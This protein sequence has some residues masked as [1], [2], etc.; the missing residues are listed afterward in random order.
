M[1][2][3]RF[4]QIEE[5][6][7]AAMA[8]EPDC[9]AAML[10]EAC[11]GDEGLRKEVEAL[12]AAEQEPASVLKH[13]LWDRRDPPVGPLAPGDRLGPYEIVSQIGAGGMGEVY[14]ARDKRLNRFVAVKVLP[15]D[16]MADTARKQRFIQEARA[17]SALNHPNI[18]TIHDIAADCDRD[19]LVMEYVAGKTLDDLIPRAGMRLGEL[20]KIA[21]QA[22]EGLGAAH[23]AGIVH[24]DLKPSNMIVS[25]NGVVK[26]LDFGLAKLREQPTLSRRPTTPFHCGRRRTK[27]QSWARRLICRRSRQKASRSM[28]AAISSVSAGCSTRWPPAAAHLRAIQMRRPWPLS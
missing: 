18:V 27:E 19:F 2:A 26:I 7:H 6:Y 12:L 24:R 22:A 11:R 25:E 23:A 5:L 21:I 3:E 1:N 9:R 20:L 15:A 16:R 10:G 8:V 13:E 4:R 28:R 17:A 14:G